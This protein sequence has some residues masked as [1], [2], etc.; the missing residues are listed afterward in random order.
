MAGGVSGRSPF[1]P[2]RLGP[3]TLR[4]RL[5]KSATFEGMSPQGEVSDE[6]VA[7]HRRFAAG[8][9]GMTTLAY[10]SATPDGRTYRHQIVLDDGAVPGLARLV[11]AVHAQGAAAAVQLG[12]AGFFAAASRTKPISPSR[13]FAP[14]GLTF[15]RSME[16]SDFARVADA[17]A[18]AGSAAARA[19]FDAVEVHLGHG[20]L[21]S[22]FLS[23]WSNRRRDRWGGD[24]EGRARFPRECLRRVREAV[25]HDVAVTAKL[26]M[27]DGFKGGLT[28]DDGTAV[29]RMLEADGSVD[30]IELTGGF[31]S[32][33]PMYLM[34]GDT[35][36]K[37]LIAHERSALRRVGLRVAGRRIMK[38]YDFEEAFFLPEARQV[39]TAVGV[40]LILLG[41]ITRLDTIQGALDKGFEFV[42]MARAL[43][44]DPDLPLR[45][46]DGTR[47]ESRC[48]PCNR[49]I[50]EM[51]IDG[52]RCVFADDAGT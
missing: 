47:T 33:N 16:A 3:V 26:N 8:G 50:V 2:A 24:P 36:I 31:T 9:V 5:I 20:Y 42:A 19:G 23:P 11:D 18:T 41:G 51:E 22:Q 32:R 35:P 27:L 29:A 38:S 45:M 14:N 17:Y 15:S 37:D 43:L 6:L 13:K 39:R 28:L 44:R 7:F 40:P 52:T 1:E 4:N 30:A 34:R 21:L 48:I 46:Q 12:H 10:C 25:G 49:C